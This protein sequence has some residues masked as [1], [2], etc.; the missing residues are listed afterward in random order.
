M[1]EQE[2]NPNWIILIMC[3]SALLALVYVNAWVDVSF[4][5]EKAQAAKEY[6]P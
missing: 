3:A 5:V 6:R 1:D 2:L 4:E